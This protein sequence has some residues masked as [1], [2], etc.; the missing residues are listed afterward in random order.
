M[1]EALFRDGE[2][3]VDVLQIG[4]TSIQQAKSFCKREEYLVPSR[5]IATL[6]ASISGQ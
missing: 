3:G 2:N 1:Q 4:G 6:V 5:E